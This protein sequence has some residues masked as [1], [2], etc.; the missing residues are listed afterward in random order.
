M[1]TVT[2]PPVRPD[3][4]LVIGADDDDP[5]LIGPFA[6]KAELIEA[7][8]ALPTWMLPPK[9]SAMANEGIWVVI[10]QDE[11][12]NFGPYSSEEDAVEVAAQ[13]SDRYGQGA[14]TR[15]VTPYDEEEDEDA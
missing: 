4:C 1:I 2:P 10:T 15:Y 11:H 7:I 3:V 12:I 9:R 13:A 8:E 14:Q 6:D 5:E